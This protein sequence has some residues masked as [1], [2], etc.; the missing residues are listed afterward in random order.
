MDRATS[1]VG[2]RPRVTA[3][4]FLTYSRALLAELKHDIEHGKGIDRQVVEDIETTIRRHEPIATVEPVDLSRQIDH[5][6]RIG[7]DNRRH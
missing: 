4:R 5:L 6:K 1:G 7:G 3:E 2:T